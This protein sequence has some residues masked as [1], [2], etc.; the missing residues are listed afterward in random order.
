MF[1]GVTFDLTLFVLTV[2]KLNMWCD[3]TFFF[4]NKDCDTYFSCTSKHFSQAKIADMTDLIKIL[5]MW[6]YSMRKF[7]C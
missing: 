4:L 1:S 5:E 7:K 2:M 3:E 6:I